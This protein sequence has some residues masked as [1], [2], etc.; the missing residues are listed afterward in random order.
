MVEKAHVAD[1]FQPLFLLFLVA[2][3]QSVQGGMRLGSKKRLEEFIVGR[4]KR[5][6]SGNCYSKLPADCRRRLGA[7]CAGQTSAHDTRALVVVLVVVVLEVQL[8]E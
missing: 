4:C 5:L 7:F 2:A 8:P 1:D 3:E 6:V